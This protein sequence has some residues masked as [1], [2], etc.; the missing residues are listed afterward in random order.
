MC[1]QSLPYIWITLI[2]GGF[3]CFSLGSSWSNASSLL[4]AFPQGYHQ[5]EF[6]PPLQFH[7]LP[8]HPIICIFFVL[9]LHT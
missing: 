7:F 6:S 2:K 5:V 4:L 9:S 8:K 1:Q 3:K